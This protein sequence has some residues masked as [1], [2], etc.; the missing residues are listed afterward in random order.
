MTDAWDEPAWERLRAELDRWAP[1]TATVWW[2]DDD[3]G[4]ASAAFDRLL[5][6]AATHPVPLALAVVPAWLDEAVAAQ[7]RAAPAGV[8]VLQ[9]GYAHQN[10][11]PPGADRA[12]G[13]PA[14]LGSAR[15]PAVA[16]TELAAGWARLSTF[17]PLRLRPALVPPWNRI[18]PAIRD[19]LPGAGLPGPLDLR[20]AR[21][22]RDGRR[23]PG[24]QHP[25]RPDRVARRE[26][27]RRGGI[28]A[29]PDH[30]PSRRTAPGAGRFP[31][32]HRAPHAPPRPDARGVGVAR[33][34]PRSPPGPR[35]GQLPRARPAAGRRGRLRSDLTPAAHAITLETD[36]TAASDVLGGRMDPS[37]SRAPIFLAPG[38]GRPYP[39]GASPRSSR[40]MAERR[41]AHT[42]SPSGG[43]SPTPRAPAPTPT[44]RTTSST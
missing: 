15:P 35:G 33:R 24:T 8:R 18:A 1:G 5:T 25:R 43:S 13:K 37:R 14:E 31:G 34:G 21:R 7:I 41:R 28:D 39:M 16:L 20:A 32:A 30:H 23:T 10:H 44:Q 27:L 9:H 4:G 40:R 26:T 12:R 11:E 38:E 2:R 42:R 36:A 6:L 19:A 3:A 29:G 22:G 17:L